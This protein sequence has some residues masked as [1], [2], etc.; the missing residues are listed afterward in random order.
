MTRECADCGATPS[1]AAFPTK[2]APRKRRDQCT[3]CASDP[4]EG[5]QQRVA[6]RRAE[7]AALKLQPGGYRAQKSVT[8]TPL[9]ASLRSR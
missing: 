7:I 3:A 9:F 5:F 1:E 6:A 8:S 4:I 2:R